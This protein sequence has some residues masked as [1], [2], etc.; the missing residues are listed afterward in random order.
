MTQAEVTNWPARV[1][2]VLAMVAL[3]M[4]AFA[5]MRAGWLRRQRRQV[6]I[7]APA[8]HPMSLIGAVAAEG[9][10]VG[11]ARTGD[12]LDR[13]AVHGL[14]VRSRA[15]MH[16]CAEGI[17]LERQG[18]PSVWLPR[19]E[20]AGVRLDRGV[21]GTV[22]G[23]DSVIVLTWASGGVSTDMSLI[24]FGFRADEGSGHALLLDGLAAAGLTVD[25][26]GN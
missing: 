1:A 17:W 18:A 16:V 24:D 23:R 20:V 6:A 22:R 9:L 11:A 14:G 5:A 21:A 10:Y 2:L 19:A 26:V 4:I 3:I 25:G 15:T 7:P 8:E 12:W 13:I